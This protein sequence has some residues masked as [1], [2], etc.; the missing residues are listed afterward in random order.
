VKQLLQSSRSGQISV[1]DL[2]VPALPPG[3]LLVQT[4]ASVLSPGTERMVLQFAEMSLAR[5]ALARPDLVRLVLEKVRRDGFMATFDAVGS[6]LD[7]PVSLGYAAAGV[8]LEAG[9]GVSELER[10]GRV[11]CAGAGFANHA[12]VICVPKNLC[13]SIPP[14]VGFEEAAFTTIGAIALHGVRLAEPTL[15][16]AIVV[17][18]LGLLGQLAVQLAKA[19]GCRVLGIDLAA[20]RV[21]LARELGADVA[22]ARLGAE[23]AAAR[24]TAGAGADAVLIT[25]DGDTNDPIELAGEVARDRAIVVAVGAVGLSIPRR[26]YYAKELRFVVSRSYGPGRYDSSYELE[27][28]DYP[29]SYV[30]WTEHRNLAAFL[31]L[32]S[33]GAVKI[34]PLISHRFSLDSAPA[35]YDLIAGRTKERS[36]GVVLTY[37]GDPDL[38]T[39]VPIAVASK[40]AAA[41]GGLHLGVLGAGAFA[42]S[43]LLPA[44]KSVENV[45]MVGI[46]SRQGVTATHLAKRF[47]FSYCTTDERRIV[48]DPNV[49]VVVVATR[50]DLH[51]SQVLAARAMGKHV[52][53]EKPLCLNEAELQRIER[54][55]ADPDSPL[56]MVG[57]N[58]R[59]APLA[60][61]LKEFFGDVS[62]PLAVHYRINAGS[63]PPE[64]W[65]RDLA[66]GG[67]RIVGEGC[68]FIDLAGWL[69][70]QR[71]C[72]V[73]SHQLPDSA[74]PSDNMV[75]TL[76]YPNGAVGT[77]A[78]LASGDRALGK[79]R[80]EVHGGGR[81]A[82]LEDFR[83][84]ELYRGGRRS[85]E[86][87]L[88]RQDKGHRAECAAFVKA[89]RDG[90]P[91]PI[92]LA[93]LAATTRASFLAV[94]SA[95]A[96]CHLEIR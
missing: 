62:D 19:S 40:G 73:A 29:I 83:R 55:F 18:G 31:D 81:S 65:V 36:L 47:A 96:G 21:Q 52:F 13:V 69:V 53:V 20:D 67:G 93:D 1:T 66:V 9:E 74:G 28:R 84:L 51:A 76:A 45:H 86:R 8:V 33:T 89:V 27:G 94:E 50:H 4:A 44:F 26:V 56:L 63:L 30:R 39:S 23:E 6:R 3:F 75:I 25:A 78:F 87:Q 85:V 17:I 54:A 61:R 82:V 37:P 41:P 49:N 48:G 70:R 5:K 35:A 14:A 71:P 90:G 15:G 88:L 16:S 91:A 77:I 38:S 57:F 68:H 79:E 64:H 32:V 60:I 59:F 24:F 2:P 46:A 42:G 80:I 34:A 92:P 7:Q 12:E 10:N 58:R 43:T 72:L 95:R 11:A 22:V